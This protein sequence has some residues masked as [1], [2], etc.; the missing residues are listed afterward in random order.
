MLLNRGMRELGLKS[1]R[2]KNDYMEYVEVLQPNT[3]KEKSDI[4]KRFKKSI[5][6]LSKVQK[7]LD[8]A[9]NEVKH[10]IR[11]VRKEHGNQLVY[12]KDMYQTLTSLLTSKITAID[13]QSSITKNIIDLEMKEKKLQREE[14]IGTT[15][16]GKTDMRG[17]YAEFFSGNQNRPSLNSTFLANPEKARRP[18]TEP[19]TQSNH[20]IN[21]TNKK[22]TQIDDIKKEQNSEVDTNDLEKKYGI[23]YGS[24]ASNLRYKDKDLKEVMHLDLKEEMYWIEVQDED[25]NVIEDARKKNI[26]TLG[27]INLNIDEG[28]VTD[29]L[30]NAYEFVEDKKENMPEHYKKQWRDRGKKI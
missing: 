14:G 25:G 30:N 4:E 20:N 13:K 9:A 26:E 6:D 7:Q 3:K 2:N 5:K 29:S 24:S 27:D 16:G 17:T 23:N 19:K 1:S 10:R 28:V 11:E 8:S 15:P 22:D 18:K 21:E 12:E